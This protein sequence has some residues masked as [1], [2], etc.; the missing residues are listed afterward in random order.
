MLTIQAL[1]RSRGITL[2]D[3]A[4]LSGIPARTIA[5]IECGLH[6]LDQRTREQLAHVFAVPPESLQPGALPA[7]QLAVRERVL[8][9]ARLLAP[10]AGAALATA[11]VL[12][13]AL[14]ALQPG[15]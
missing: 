12:A 7:L 9:E 15:P 1:R 5:A 2:I 13:P 11:L 8:A 14:A 6:H 3:L 4:L 10:V